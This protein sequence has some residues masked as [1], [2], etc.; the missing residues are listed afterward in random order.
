MFKIQAFS[1][2]AL[3]VAFTNGKIG[4]F[5]PKLTESERIN[6]L[7]HYFIYGK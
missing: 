7:V 6:E 4:Q 1:K 2:H 3:T 5:D